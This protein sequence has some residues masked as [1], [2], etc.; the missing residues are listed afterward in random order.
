MDLFDA[1]P[2]AAPNA[3]LELRLAG[4]LSFAI[5]IIAGR[6]FPVDSSGKY[7]LRVTPPGIFVAI[8]GLIYLNFLVASAGALWLDCWRPSSWLLFA[9]WNILGGLWSYLFSVA[10]NTYMF[11]SNIAI[12]GLLW[13]M[14]ALWSDLAATSGL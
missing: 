14:E 12:F 6:I 11:L 2:G 10:T 13:L 9:G 4:F 3:P 5:P 7:R 8:W 1:A